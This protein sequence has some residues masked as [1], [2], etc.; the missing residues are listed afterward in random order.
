VEG[1][2]EFARQSEHDGAAFDLNFWR[3]SGTLKHGGLSASLRR[4][5]LEGDGVRGFA[6]PLATLHA[7]QGWADVFVNTP[8]DGVVD[9]AATISYAWSMEGPISRPSLALVAQDFE[10]D[11]N[12]RDFGREL[13]L[14]FGASLP[15]GLGIEAKLASFNGDSGFADRDKIW[16]SLSWSH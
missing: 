9:T 5:V 16:L 2:G 12:T 10:S 15:H 7:Y 6:T 14:R 13:G 3:V 8:A 4:E 1:L 11:R